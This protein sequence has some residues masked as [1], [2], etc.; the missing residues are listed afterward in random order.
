MNKRFL[1]GAVG[2]LLLAGLAMASP[3]GKDGMWSGVVSDS[4]CGGSMTDSACVT[5]CVKEKG[6]KYVLVDDASKKVF[7][8]N[9]QDDA[10]KHAG[11][12]V[13]V[14]GSVD[15]DTITAKEI[16]MPKAGK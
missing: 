11:H 2:G 8:L 15:G 6:A 14:T 5:K 10:A 12:H 13:S 16:S 9:P 4:Q 1:L 7:T 3:A